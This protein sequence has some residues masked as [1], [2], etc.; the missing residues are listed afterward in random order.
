MPFNKQKPLSHLVNQTLIHL[1]CNNHIKSTRCFDSVEGR[2]SIA[3]RARGSQAA[4][5]RERQRGDTGERCARLLASES[6]EA[7]LETDEE[8]GGKDAEMARVRALWRTAC[9]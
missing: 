2:G 3:P 6:L 7:N 8:N 5:W 1:T 4:D 9:K